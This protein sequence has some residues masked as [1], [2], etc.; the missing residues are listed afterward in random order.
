MVAPD[1]DTCIRNDGVMDDWGQWTHGG[2][3]MQSTFGVMEPINM[4]RLNR[5]RKKLKAVSH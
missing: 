1:S 4:E 3:E 5:V 2:G